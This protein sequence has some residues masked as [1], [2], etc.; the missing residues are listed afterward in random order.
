VR[1]SRADSLYS[2]HTPGLRQDLLP[3][4]RQRA[5]ERIRKNMK[6]LYDAN[7]LE[8]G[9]VPDGGWYKWTNDMGAAEDAATAHP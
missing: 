4:A 8:L 9:F 6:L 3:A 2:Y 7:A 1:I 5:L